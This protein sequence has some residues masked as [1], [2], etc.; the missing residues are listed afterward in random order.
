[1]SR[2][3]IIVG[4]VRLSYLSVFAP[5]KSTLNDNT[6]FTCT[7][8][9]PKQPTPQC[10]DPK[11]LL[12]RVKAHCKAIIT[13][14]WGTKPPAG[15]RSPIRDGDTDLDGNGQPRQPG[16]WFIRASSSD[17]YPPLTIDGDRNVVTRD[18]GWDSGD[19][20]YVKIG[21]YPYDAAGNRGVSM[22]LYGVQFTV[23][24]EHFGSRT[25]ADEFEK[26]GVSGA[27]SS[28]SADEYDPFEDQ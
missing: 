15:L 14:K 6:E 10:A 19:W 1:M 18:S 3:T 13:E 2:S 25:T 17:A 27:P 20:G 16:Y 12:D 26:V 23:R 9:I 7:L 5:R 21:G 22:G 4:P 28:S 11:A 24:D 8:L